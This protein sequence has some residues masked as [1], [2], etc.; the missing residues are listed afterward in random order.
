M[1]STKRDIRLQ[2]I[3]KV[4]NI[5]SDVKELLMSSP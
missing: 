4:I 2:K 3:D 1:L 5:F